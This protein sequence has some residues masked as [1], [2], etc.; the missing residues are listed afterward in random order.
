MSIDTKI[1]P[2]MILIGGAEISIE[3]K[4]MGQLQ[5]GP[6]NPGTIAVYCKSKA[7]NLALDLVADGCDVDFVSVAG[8]DFAGMAMKAQLSKVGVGVEHFHLLDGQDTAATHEILNL[9]DQPEMEFKNQDV[10]SCMTIDMIDQAANRI[11]SAYL[12]L[13]ETRFSEEIIAHIVA[14]FPQTPILLLPD[15]EETAA[16]AKPILGDIEGILVGR[17]EAEVLSGLSILSEDEMLAAG[18]WF[19]DQGIEQVFFNLGFGGVYFKDQFEAGVKRPGPIR[20]AS[21]AEGFVQ[22]KP[23]AETANKSLG[24]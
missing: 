1:R 4:P 7:W 3:N 18:Q 17:R 20:I 6:D 2:K 19:F 16:R 23:A 12:I 10:F 22:R 5:F 8:N 9:L 11:Q 21:I 15:S 13:L 24:I 14:S